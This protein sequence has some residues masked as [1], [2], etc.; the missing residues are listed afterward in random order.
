MRGFGLV[1]LVAQAL[2]RAATAPS[3]A[4]PGDPTVF[5]RTPKREYVVGEPIIATVRLGSE[6]SETPPEFFD[7]ATF[8]TL[9]TFVFTFASPEGQ[10]I[11]E[12]TMSGA[13]AGRVARRPPFKPGEFVQCD[14]VIFPWTR[15]RSTEEKPTPL[16]PG[17]YTVR[18][19]VLWNPPEVL[20]GKLRYPPSRLLVS[21]PVNIRI[22]APTGPEAEALKLMLSSDFRG[23]FEGELGGRSAVIDKVLEKYPAC[24]Y[25]RYAR[26]RILLDRAAWFRNYRR[27]GVSGAEREEAERL[28]SEALQYAQL[29][30]MKPLADNVLL[31][32]A[33]LQEVLH[34]RPDVARTLGLI[35]RQFPSSD[36]REAAEK[37]LARMPQALRDLGPA[38]LPEPKQEA[39]EVPSGQQPRWLV[40]GINVGG[41]LA[42]GL[43]LY[44]LRR[45]RRT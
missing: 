40:P 32:R 42:L 38:T 34:D 24:T 3:G 26:V 23:F 9:G 22:T 14:K 11:A 13:D 16:K 44:V 4:T 28:V 10:T 30:D 27:A 2:L 33:R 43:V 25:A 18:V 35:I 17:D 6:T 39:A 5:L 7:S 29:P 37:W 36:A 15:A 45:K 8:G 31:S 21:N 1:V 19:K 41:L 20:D 12:V